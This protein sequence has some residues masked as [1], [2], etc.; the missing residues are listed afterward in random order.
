MMEGLDKTGTRCKQ[1]CPI[2]ISPDKTGSIT[3]A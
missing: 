2:P 1:V 3:H